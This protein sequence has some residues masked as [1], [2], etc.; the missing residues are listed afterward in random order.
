[1]NYVILDSIRVSKINSGFEKIS[2]ERLYIARK[3]FCE[4]YFINISKFIKQ[5]LG[6]KI[7]SLYTNISVFKILALYL[8]HI[9]Y[10]IH[11]S[12]I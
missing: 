9:T 1:M 2:N 10:T 7:S 3:Q 5:L 12:V 4:L 11:N 6:V 8:Y